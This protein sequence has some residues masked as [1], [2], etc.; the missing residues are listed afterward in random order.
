MTRQERGL[1]AQSA[2]WCRRRRRLILTCWLLALLVITATSH[3]A[4]ISYPTKFSLPN[5]PSTK[6]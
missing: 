2:K 5:S 6:P 1:I 3:A 4:G